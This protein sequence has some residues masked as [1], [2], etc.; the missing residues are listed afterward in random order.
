M[1]VGIYVAG[2]SREVWFRGS[3]DERRVTLPNCLDRCAHD[4]LKL[5]RTFDYTPTKEKDESI[6]L[7]KLD[8]LSIVLGVEEIKV[9]NGG[10]LNVLWDS[11]PGWL[12]RFD[13]CYS[14]FSSS[15]FSSIILKRRF[16]ELCFRQSLSCQQTMASQGF[17][18]GKWARK[19]D[20]YRSNS[21]FSCCHFPRCLRSTMASG[22]R[23]PNPAMRMPR[24]CSI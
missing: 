1:K 6:E 22:N 5:N 7:E 20:E 23:V 15:C 10:R 19:P 12:S 11:L 17:S 24:R 2:V 8:G 18:L 4:G 14:I 9:S 16:S 21:T 13:G 3:R